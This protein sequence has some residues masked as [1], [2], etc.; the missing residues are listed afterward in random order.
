MKSQSIEI[1]IDIYSFDELSSE[2][3]SLTEVAKNAVTTSYSPYSEFK[4]GAAILLENGKIF[5]ASNQ[6]NAAYPSGLC[7][8][9]VA[10][11]Y[12]NAQQPQIPVSAIAIAAYTKGKFIETPITPCGACRQVLLETELRFGK[13]IDIYLLGTK[14]IFHIGGAQQLLPLC[15]GKES[16]N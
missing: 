11:F 1:K 12:A 10:M 5:S 2:I 6:E 13:K 15:F 7:A 14:E 9:R 8:E 4:V 16:L 3:K